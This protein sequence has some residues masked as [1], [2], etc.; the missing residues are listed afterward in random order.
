[1]KFGLRERA[2]RVPKPEVSPSATDIDA[3]FKATVA[4]A[5]GGYDNPF[6][7]TRD[8]Q[9]Y[10]RPQN[11]ESAPAAPTERN[12]ASS[13]KEIPRWKRV[14]L[15][16]SAVATASAAL[17]GINGPAH[18]NNE[19]PRPTTSVTSQQ[20]EG[21]P[22]N[23]DLTQPEAGDV[24]VMVGS[25]GN[26]GEIP[27]TTG[28]GEV[29]NGVGG[30][31]KPF[32]VVA[33]QYPG[34]VLNVGVKI[35][36]GMGTN[37]YA[38]S[39]EKGVQ[40][41]VEYIN[42][43]DSQNTAGYS[44]GAHA[45]ELAAIQVALENPDK[46]Y[47]VNVGG[48]PLTPGGIAERVNGSPLEAPMAALGFAFRQEELPPNMT[49]IYHAVENDPYANPT[50][51]LPV[52]LKAHYGQT[53]FPG[54]FR[55]DEIEVYTMPNGAKKIVKRMRLS[56]EEAFGLVPPRPQGEPKVT[57]M[58]Q[59]P[60]VY[61]DRPDFNTPE[62]NTAVTTVTAGLNQVEAAGI[63]TPDQGAQAEQVIADTAGQI[64]DG[65]TQFN[66]QVNAEVVRVNDQVAA[67]TEQIETQVNQFE[68]E[69]TAGYE[70]AVA[71]TEQTFADAQA[72]I[73]DQIQAFARANDIT[74]PLPPQ[75][76]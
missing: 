22:I 27:F 40:G 11:T 33:H 67:A 12:R 28:E 31:D 9:P 64:D 58:N 44:Q 6:T 15:K 8:T 32:A 49:V 29:M 2:P 53:Y 52:G 74:L 5:Y 25:S 51:N 35:G 24:T 66:A 20:F 57:I 65:I 42:L 71:Q 54:Q 41:A 36:M 39:V 70:A 13:E 47:I 17:M 30:P 72:Q 60:E 55:T 76:Q 50:L 59:A 4:A 16:L 19:M 68:Q 45:A 75:A 69:I 26:G 18:A 37:S 46:Q 48:S 10:Y 7:V 3:H 14:A 21:V 62:V 73:N 63:I 56:T 23:P 1:M 38:E 43:Y 34:E 61:T